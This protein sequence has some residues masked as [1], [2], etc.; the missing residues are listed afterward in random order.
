MYF[1]AINVTI[2]DYQCLTDFD[3]G[4]LIGHC[5]VHFAFVF[6]LKPD[7]SLLPRY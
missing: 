6:A 7:Q 3:S 4:N 5:Y 2:V 1:L